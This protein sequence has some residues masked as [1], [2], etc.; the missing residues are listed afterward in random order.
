MENRIYVSVDVCFDIYGQMMPTNI[1]WEDGSVY[2]IDK[3]TD[4][5]QAAAAKS[6]GQG[7][8]YTVMIA[9]KEKYLFFERSC[10]RNGNLIG[11]WFVERKAM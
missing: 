10:A 2:P 6:G 11:S 5:R 4:I 1:K 7:D 8:R 3:V 9:G